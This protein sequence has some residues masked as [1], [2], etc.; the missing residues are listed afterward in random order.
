M[1]PPEAETEPAAATAPVVN[2]TDRAS[3]VALQ[4]LAHL[5]T[6]YR[7]GGLSPRTGFDCSGLVAYVYRQGAGLALPRNTFDLS[8]LG[9]PVE[10]AALR[11]GDLVF[12]NTQR[13][14]YSHVGIYL[15][16]DRFIH[17]PASGGEVRVEDLRAGY[18]M[19]R[20]DGARRII[21]LH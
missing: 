19:R 8:R 17:A 5:G 7:A 4:A 2:A 3:S 1:R 11:A 16:E 21:A 9:E 13:R 12:Y 18:W 20:Y 15:G 14:E 6:P 10:R